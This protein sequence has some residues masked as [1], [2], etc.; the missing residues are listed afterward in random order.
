MPRYV[1]TAN[2]SKAYEKP[3]RRFPVFPSTPRI[4]NFL[5]QIAFP[6]DSLDRSAE[7]DV[8]ILCLASHDD[9]TF[10]SLACMVRLSAALPLVS[11]P[12]P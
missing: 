3:N 6:L 11:F 12:H 7:V 9:W 2:A 1:T 5:L 10:L 8:L 4:V